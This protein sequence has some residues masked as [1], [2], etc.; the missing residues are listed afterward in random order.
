MYSDR[1]VRAIQ[2]CLKNRIF[3]NLKFSQWRSGML[4]RMPCRLANS[5]VSKDRQGQQFKKS[6]PEDAG[7]QIL[8]NVGNY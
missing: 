3:G 2:G 5:G 6:D 7:T 4:R 1:R 8:R